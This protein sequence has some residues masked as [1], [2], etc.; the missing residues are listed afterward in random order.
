MQ[1]KLEKLA[2]N[3]R[4]FWNI[5]PSTAI[6]DWYF[7]ATGNLAWILTEQEIY[8]NSDPMSEAV[9]RIVRTL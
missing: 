7:D 5:W 6:V 8:D 1:S 2:R 4:I 3:D 9:T